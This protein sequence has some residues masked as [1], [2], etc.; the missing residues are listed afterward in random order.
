MIKNAVQVPGFV[1]DI[2]F[3]NEKSGNKPY[4]PDQG[5]ALRVLDEFPVPPSLVQ[6][7]GNGIHAV[8]FG[9]EPFKINNRSDR[10]KIQSILK[11]FQRKLMEHFRE[12][13][14]EI[15]NV[16]DLVRLYRIPGTFNHKSNPP[17]PV[18]LIRYEPDNR[19]GFDDI[20][21]LWADK[22]SKSARRKKDFPLADHQQIVEEC[23]WY[24]HCTTSGAASCDEPNWYAAG[25]VTACCK[26]GERIFH[27]YSQ[28]HPGYKRDEAEAKFRRAR[29]EAGP[30]TCQSIRQD[31]GQDLFCQACPHWGGI[32]SP[33]QLGHVYDPG[34]IGPIPLGYT[35]QGSY[36]LLDQV[37]EIIIQAS[38]S[39]LLS[40]QFLLGLADSGFWC[41][42]YGNEKG[43]FNCIGAGEDLIAA[44]KRMGPF[45]P[46]KIRGRGVWIEGD[47]VIVNLGAEIPEDVE[48]TYLCF[49]SLPI[50]ENQEFDTG[51]LRDLL[52]QF[53]WRN[54]QDAVLFLGWLAIAPI[55][56]ALSWRPHCFIYG[57]PNSGKST[58]H[59]L[60]SVLLSPLRVAA[61]G[62]S[63]EAGI[64][65]VLGPDSLP[66]IIDE[67]ETDQK[68]YRLAGII[69]LARSASSADSPVLR[70]TPEG[71]ALQYS[72]RTM[73]LFSAVNVT[74]MSP[75]DETRILLFELVQHDSNE[76]VGKLIEAERAYFE[77]LGPQWC[78][79]MASHAAHINAAISIFKLAM[80]SIDSR[81]RQ[82]MA[83]LLA[84]A[85]VALEG[86]LP[87]IEEAGF[88]VQD[89]LPSVERHAIAHERD[90]AGECLSYLFA[91]MV[92]ED[93]GLEFPLGHWLGSESKAMTGGRPE[94]HI[95]DS[96]RIVASFDMRIILE[97]DNQGLLIR[98]G[99]PAI[100]RV[101]E[102]TKWANGAWQ[103]ALGQI[104]GAFS[105]PNPIYFP[106][107]KKKSRC[108][109][110]PLDL[111]P[112][113]IDSPQKER[114]Y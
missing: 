96:M 27:E 38:S 15:D 59:G 65:Q 113:P 2:D 89:Y 37:R 55:C 53:P 47:R 44:C 16:G 35:S 14:F 48:H 1:A 13:G 82:N 64:R 62:Q 61:D 102:G 33:V 30:R 46:L 56:G 29:E 76:E 93:R 68:N 21:E 51:R 20:D 87:S 98:N 86:R 85:F 49:D 32:S 41:S 57:P 72:L 43:S 101:F 104:E 66:I 70:G 22:E 83:T 52:A 8:W 81:H 106:S 80:P 77:G 6:N 12:H 75:A 25:S 108:V 17:K 84:G 90:D 110:L 50:A 9:A 24:R 92:R 4:P 69:R 73:F 26:D 97:G 58:I 40:Y 19:I 111:I 5:T 100:N 94:N 91:H 79:Y 78:G 18:T 71:N 42:R 105:L 109:G 31:L 63:T 45:S 114:R 103:R 112:D 39:Q 60:A 99:S 28:R 10:R 107:T 95:S 7:T 34:T 74:G 23:A 3:A 54:P 67:F 88:W 36:A 11:K